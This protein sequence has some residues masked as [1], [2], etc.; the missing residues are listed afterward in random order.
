MGNVNKVILVGRLGRDIE[1]KYTPNGTA[2]GKSSIATTEYFKD[3]KG[4]RQ[5]RTEWH[6]LEI[7]GKMAENANTYLHKGSLVYFE[8]RLKTD[9]YEK[10]KEKKYFTKVV[11]EKMQF[12]DSKKSDNSGA[13][14]VNESSASEEDLPF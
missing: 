1:L 6:N 9:V 3:D 11:V 2:V 10:D 14:T 13:D 8:G 5:E 4:E 7:W 12:L